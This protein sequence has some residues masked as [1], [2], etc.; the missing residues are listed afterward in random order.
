VESEFVDLAGHDRIVQAAYLDEAALATAGPGDRLIDHDKD[1]RNPAGARRRPLNPLPAR[2]EPTMFRNDLSD[3]NL[4][5]GHRAAGPRPSFRPA[6]EAL[7]E[8][9]ALS[10][11]TVSTHTFNGTYLASFFGQVP[12]MKG[13]VAVQG[14]AITVT[15]RGFTIEGTINVNV[16]VPGFSLQLQGQAALMRGTTPILSG[17]WMVSAYGLVETGTFNAVQLSKAFLPTAGIVLA[18]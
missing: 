14:S 18:M 8:R 6:V 5:G 10:S 15:I 2:K 12:T 1:L 9:V 4:F 7:E 11:S 13:P 17:T 16:T 3:V